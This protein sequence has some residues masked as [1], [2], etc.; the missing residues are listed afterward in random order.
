V[1]RQNFGRL[2]ILLCLFF[3]SGC[4]SGQKTPTPFLLDLKS[5]NASNKANQA[6]KYTLLF[7]GFQCS[8]KRDAIVIKDAMAITGLRIGDDP[9]NAFNKYLNQ[10]MIRHGLFKKITT[11]ESKTH[12][13]EDFIASGEIKLVATGFE[14]EAH[15][16]LRVAATI[17]AFATL[18]VGMI[19]AMQIN[20]WQK[21]EIGVAVTFRMVRTTDYT[22]VVNKAYV[23]SKEGIKAKKNISPNINEVLNHIFKNIA[24]EIIKEIEYAVVQGG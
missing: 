8:I 1:Y 9:S 20:E 23:I 24:D 12:E 22:N 13:D 2:A 4:A 18:N 21:Q 5:P 7:N 3:F 19:E 10:E 14:S 17:L 6:P 15:Q 11:V 16:A